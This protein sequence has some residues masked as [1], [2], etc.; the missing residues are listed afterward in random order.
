MT[1]IPEITLDMI[2]VKEFS[3][4]ERIQWFAEAWGEVFRYSGEEERPSPVAAL[5]AMF[6]SVYPPMTVI[7]AS[8]QG[9]R[10]ASEELKQE[11]KNGTQQGN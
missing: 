4:E 3:R 9:Y 2:A 6:R 5:S 7:I 11:Q 10:M 8:S 1:E